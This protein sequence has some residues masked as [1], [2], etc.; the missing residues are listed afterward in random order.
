MFH[1]GRENLKDIEQFWIDW[2]AL[3]KTKS[4][5]K[6]AR[7]LQEAVLQKDGIEGLAKITEEVCDV[8]PSLYLTVMEL[9]DKNHDYEQIEKIG[10]QAMEKIDKKFKIRGKIALRAAYASSY[11][12]HIKNMMQFCWECFYSDATVR[13]YLRLFG[14][15]EMAAQYG[16]QGKL[17][18]FLELR[19]S[20]ILMKTRNC[21]EI[22]GD[23]GYHE[24]CFYTGDF[25]TAKNAS[26]NPQGSLDGVLVLLDAAFDYFY[27]IYMRENFR[28][29]QQR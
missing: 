23:V 1:V 25:E 13:N 4:G 5:D 9:Y 26:R 12:M 17:V 8:H 11:Q 7:L 15:D 28:H 19:R 10:A 3:L 24:L 16:M 21:V 22:L 29:R 2:I 20:Q 14:T 18:L 6:E 27:C